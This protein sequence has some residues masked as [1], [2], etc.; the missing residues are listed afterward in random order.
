MFLLLSRLPLQVEEEKKVVVFAMQSED[1]KDVMEVVM[2]GQEAESLLCRGNSPLA[3]LMWRKWEP[4]CG[5]HDLAFNNDNTDNPYA[6]PFS[7][8]NEV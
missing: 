4:W 3:L 5:E 7:A 2:E 1:R 6:M 8:D